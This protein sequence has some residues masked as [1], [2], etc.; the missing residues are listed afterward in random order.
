MSG[1]KTRRILKNGTSRSS[2]LIRLLFLALIPLLFLQLKLRNISEP[3][4]AILLP[5]GAG[6]LRTTGGHYTAFETECLVEDTTGTRH[7]LSTDMVLDTVPKN[8]QGFVI[9]RGFGINEGREVRRRSLSLAG[10][11]LDL[12]FGRPLTPLQ[13][14]HTRV[15]VRFRIRQTLGIEAVRI[16]ILTYAITTFYDGRD[17][18]PGEK[19]P[20]LGHG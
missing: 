13:I 15:W 7:V 17:P 10:Q 3:Y 12:Q 11:R 8:Y 5:A 20:Q 2:R 16:H 6:L 18:P 9:D 1:P 19:A 14:E 4:P